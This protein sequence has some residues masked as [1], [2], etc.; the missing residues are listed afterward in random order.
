[1]RMNNTDDRISVVKSSHQALGIR[2]TART[3][4]D[5]SGTAC[6]TVDGDSGDGFRVVRFFTSCARDRFNIAA[7][8]SSTRA[9]VSSARETRAR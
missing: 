2:A 4:R 6:D 3:T 5:K 8:N 1:M 7:D 9:T